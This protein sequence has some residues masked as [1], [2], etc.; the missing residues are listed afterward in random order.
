MDL[1]VRAATVPFLLYFAVQ[2][3]ITKGQG[4]ELTCPSIWYGGDLLR[5]VGEVSKEAIKNQ[6]PAPQSISFTQNALV[7]CEVDHNLQ[8][9]DKASEKKAC[10]CQQNATSYLFNY[11]FLVDE[12]FHLSSLKYNVDIRCSKND[13][14]SSPLNIT[15]ASGCTHFRVKHKDDPCRFY[16]CGPGTCYVANN[17]KDTALCLCPPAHKQPL[18]E[19]CGWMCDCSSHCGYLPGCYCC[20]S[21]VVSFISLLLVSATMAECRKI[22]HKPA[23]VRARESFLYSRHVP[24]YR[25]SNASVKSLRLTFSAASTSSKRLLENISEAPN[26]LDSQIESSVDTKKASS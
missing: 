12:L 22:S 18:C 21:L 9:C 5:L 23:Q 7:A 10:W 15:S 20:L 16:K 14:G 25:G 2:I 1:T 8:L 3:H 4:V 13:N 24:P 26:P 19:K 6:C 11:R 17:A